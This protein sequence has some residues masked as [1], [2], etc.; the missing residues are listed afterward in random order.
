[1][2]TY[3]LL[4]ALAAGVAAIAMSQ[5][6]EPNRERL[7]AQHDVE[8]QRTPHVGSDVEVEALFI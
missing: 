5:R 1:M 7:R 8:P 2:K 4:L 6:Q 3:Y